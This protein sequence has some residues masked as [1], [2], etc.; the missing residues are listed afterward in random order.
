MSEVWYSVLKQLLYSA[1][2]FGVLAIMG[3]LLTAFFVANAFLWGGILQIDFNPPKDKSRDK[4]ILME[5]LNSYVR[6][7][8]KQHERA[9]RVLLQYVD[10]DEITKAMNNIGEWHV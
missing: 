2:C 5:K 4:E 1:T 8:S 6:D 9:C 7:G 10:D 3:D